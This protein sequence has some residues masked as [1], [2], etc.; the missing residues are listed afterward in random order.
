[1]HR[2]IT[3][4]SFQNERPCRD[5]SELPSPYSWAFEYLVP[6]SDSLERI[7]R[8]GL[9]RR[10]SSGWKSF[11]VSNYTCHF[12]WSFSSSFLVCIWPLTWFYPMPTVLILCC[13][14]PILMVMGS[15][16]SGTIY[17]NKS[18]LLRCLGFLIL[19]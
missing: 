2:Q 19:S 4:L 13:H 16:P 7:R 17:Q 10:L 3:G 9:P 1:M 8:S 6:I 12:L 15:Y 5:L 18:L 11:A 14:I